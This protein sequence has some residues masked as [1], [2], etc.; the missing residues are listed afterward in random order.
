VTGKPPS[1]S[2]AYIYGYHYAGNPT[3]EDVGYHCSADPKP[4]P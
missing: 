3:F 4:P 1:P 2:G